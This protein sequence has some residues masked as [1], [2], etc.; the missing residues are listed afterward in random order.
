[1]SVEKIVKD[2]FTVIG[3]EGS[4]NDGEGFIQNL[5]AQANAR[6]AEISDLCKRDAQ[7]NFAG[8]WGAMSDFSRNFLPWTDFSQGLYLAGAECRDDAAPPD[9]WT[10]WVV[11]ACMY[12]R[13][14]CDAYSFPQAMD[15]M[16]QNGFTLAGAVHDFTDPRTGKNYI[17]API[18]RKNDI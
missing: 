7:G 1:M 13:F 14:D 4:T 3:I 2:S 12:L 10:K 11:P 18:E 9:G 15:Y 5:W 17:Y 6:F 8:F 16:Q